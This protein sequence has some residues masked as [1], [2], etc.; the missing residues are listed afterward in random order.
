MILEPYCVCAFALAR[1]VPEMLRRPLSVRL[2]PT[3]ARFLLARRTQSA[4]SGLRSTPG[5]AARR[6][7]EKYEGPAV[8]HGVGPGTD[9]SACSPRTDSKRGF[10]G[11]RVYP[12]HVQPG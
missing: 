9:R 6:S 5:S 11:S 10:H 1:T 3:L 8:I 7:W 2:Q 12:R 4:H